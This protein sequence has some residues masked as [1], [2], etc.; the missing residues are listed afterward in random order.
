MPPGVGVPDDDEALDEEEEEDDV[1]FPLPLDELEL[2]D[3]PFGMPD[4]PP[5]G[6]LVLLLPQ[7]R[8]ASGISA[9]S[10]NHAFN[11][12]TPVGPRARLRYSRSGN[13]DRERARHQVRP[14]RPSAAR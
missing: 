5:D 10:H 3:V 14:R 11:G 9:A 8:G 12:A 7:A 13:H 6:L 2:L 4:E 1:V